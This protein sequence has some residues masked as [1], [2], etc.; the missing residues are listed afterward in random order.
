MSTNQT[1]AAMEKIGA[2][3]V[4]T[5]DGFSA[6][7]DTNQPLAIRLLREDALGEIDDTYAVG[8]ARYK[9]AL[10]VVQALD[11]ERFSEWGQNPLTLM[12]EEVVRLVHEAWEAGTVVGDA[13]A[14]AELALAVE[15]RICRRCNGAGIECRLPDR[16]CCPVCG[17]EGT[18]PAGDH[19]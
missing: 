9:K 17:G 11:P 4:R 1:A 3:F 2:A 7:Q 10:A 16:P 13:F 8:W 19:D 14:K 15:R 6:G 12:D 5:I 18:V